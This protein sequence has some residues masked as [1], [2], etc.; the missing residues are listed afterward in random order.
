MH[1]LCVNWGF[2]LNYVSKIQLSWLWNF[3][4]MQTCN[5][6]KHRNI[7]TKQEKNVDTLAHFLWQFYCLIIEALTLFI[8]KAL[9]LE[10]HYTFHLNLKTTDS[11]Q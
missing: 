10:L 11:V 5:I 1:L 9:P 6:M 2:H 4:L 7:E 3:T 8:Q